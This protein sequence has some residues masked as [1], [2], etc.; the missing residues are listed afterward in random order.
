MARI[1][2]D[3]AGADPQRRFSPYCWR[4]KL[5]LAHKGL[6]FET[7]P[8]RFTEKD[9]IAFS[10]QGR[11]PVLVDG[12]RTIFDSWTIANYLEDAYPGTPSLFGG[13]G[14]RAASRTLNNW[15][16]IVLTPAI[17]RVVLVDIFERIHEKDRAYF[18]ESREQRFG[19]KLEDV[20]AD[21]D[22]NIK[23][24]RQALDPVRAT[25]KAQ[26]YLGGDAPLYC[27]YIVFGHLQWARCISPIP[28]LDTG[29][30]VCAWRERLLDAHDGFARKCPAYTA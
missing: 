3:L 6:S 30:P 28:L 7:V 17:A 29:D 4:T 5:A 24:L 1:L 21:R 25:L 12:E 27:D 10:G 13:A 20:V 19:A 14:G 16:D 26:P 9:V 23:A 15:A 11:V 8:W 2:Y 18:R 22:G